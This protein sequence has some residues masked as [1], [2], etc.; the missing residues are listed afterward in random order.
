VRFP[1]S[2]Q[3]ITAVAKPT[4]LDIG[5]VDDLGLIVGVLFDMVGDVDEFYPLLV[6]V[7]FPLENRGGIPARKKSLV[8]EGDNLV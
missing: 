8:E 7:A 4:V 6:G 3:P 2:T 5:V 1:S